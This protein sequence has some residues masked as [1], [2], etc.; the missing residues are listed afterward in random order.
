[1]LHPLNPCPLLTVQGLCE[2][3]CTAAHDSSADGGWTGECDDGGPEAAYSDCAYGTDCDDCGARPKCALNTDCTDCGGGLLLNITGGASLAD[4]GPQTFWTIVMLLASAGSGVAAARRAPH[5]H[6][7]C[8]LRRALRCDLARNL[9]RQ[10]RLAYL[11]KQLTN[12][13]STLSLL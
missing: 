6:L 4:P 7:P 9:P 3:T 11:L 12:K 13:A 8:A 5:L 2:N 1:M 10:A